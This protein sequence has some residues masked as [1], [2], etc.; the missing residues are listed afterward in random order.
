MNEAEREHVRNGE[1]ARLSLW[2]RNSNMFGSRGFFSEYGQYDEREHVAE[3]VR[4]AWVS[5]IAFIDPLFVNPNP[6]ILAQVRVFIQHGLVVPEFPRYVQTLLAFRKLRMQQAAFEETRAVK[7]AFLAAYPGTHYRA[8]VEL[9]EAEYVRSERGC[10]E[11]VPRYKRVL[12]SRFK[13]VEAYPRALSMLV[14]CYEEL[15]DK[16]K[17]EVARA[18]AL[19]YSNARRGGKINL[20]RVGVN[21]ELVR[22]GILDNQ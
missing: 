22:A 8:A 15:G 16:D 12:V 5:P 2:R 7:D 14:E 10:G 20:H 3:N 1:M 21:Q 17:H 19:N 9:Q 4:A 18:A 11:A 6:S 13:P